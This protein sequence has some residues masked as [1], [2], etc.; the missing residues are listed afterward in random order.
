MEIIAWYS[1]LIVKRLL[2]PVI[3]L[4]IHLVSFNFLFFKEAT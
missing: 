1:L 2:R 4:E 3:V